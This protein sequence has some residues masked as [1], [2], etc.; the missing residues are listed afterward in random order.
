[1]RTSVIPVA[2][3]AALAA[4]PLGAQN[5]TYEMNAQVTPRCGVYSSSGT[6]I[7]VNFGS[8]ADVATT[9]TVSV[10]A[11]SAT[12]RCNGRTG[13]TRTIT[14]Q[15]NGWLTLDGNPTTDASRRIRFNMQ[16]GGGS[17]MGFP[18]QQLTAPLSR[19]FPGNPTW[20][21]GQTGGITFQAFGV[22]GAPAA[23]GVPGTTVLA[24]N[25]R[26]TVTI[27]VTAN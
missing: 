8:L 2:G 16:H 25:Y 26:D 19:S 23:N 24:G 20:L 1:M 15:N 21:A 9:A 17:G 13:F 27:T 7:D 10:G 6:V 18:T 4:A 3:L 12:Y 14:S 22:R 11:G 5:L